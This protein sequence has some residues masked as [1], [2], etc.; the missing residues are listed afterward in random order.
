[1]KHTTPVSSKGTTVSI[2]W[3]KGTDLFQSRSSVPGPAS[4]VKINAQKT[5]AP[6]YGRTLP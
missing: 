2:T 5:G 1:M 6:Y 4:A 3:G